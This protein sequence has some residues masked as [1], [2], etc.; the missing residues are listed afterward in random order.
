VPFSEFETFKLLLIFR[1]A[2]QENTAFVELNLVAKGPFRPWIVRQP[3][4]FQHFALGK[5]MLPVRNA[6]GTF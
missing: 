6:I 2:G 1:A 5:F 3:I 4:P